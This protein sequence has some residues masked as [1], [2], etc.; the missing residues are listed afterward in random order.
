MKMNGLLMKYYW[1]SFF[2][3]NFILSLFSCC[4]LFFVGK[5]IFNI[6]FFSQ[7]SW[8]VI[9]ALFLGWSIAQVSLTA[10]VQIFI[11]NSR[12][13]TIVGYLLSI[14]SSLVGQ[15]ISTVVY[16]YPFEIPIPLLFYPPMALARGV[17]LIG[18][19]CANNSNCFQDIWNLNN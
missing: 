18:Y 11:N 14:F 12:T 3:F 9:F 2:I 16:P 10:F 6:I 15:A 19:S 4:F 13:A 5:Y 8:K 7:T 17:Y 1:I